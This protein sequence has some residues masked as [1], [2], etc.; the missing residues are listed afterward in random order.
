MVVAMAEGAG[1][2]VTVEAATAAEATVV[3][4]TVVVREVP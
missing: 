4:A 3:V 2:E 1:A